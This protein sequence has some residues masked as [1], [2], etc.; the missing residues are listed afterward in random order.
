MKT[1]LPEGQDFHAIFGLPRTATDAPAR[2]VIGLC[3]LAL[4]FAFW[5]SNLRD[6]VA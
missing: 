2:L 6:R 1:N 4:A 5:S 3:L